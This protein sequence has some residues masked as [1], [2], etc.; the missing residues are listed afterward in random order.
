MEKGRVAIEREGALVEA[1]R[2]PW[3]I[4]PFDAESFDVAVIRICC[5]ADRHD[6][7]GR[8]WEM[9]RVLRP[10]DALVIEPPPAGGGFGG[11]RTPYRLPIRP[12]AGR[13]VRRCP[14]DVWFVGVRD[15]CR[16]ADGAQFTSKENSN[17]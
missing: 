16:K 9:L 5:R 3:G 13:P 2:A 17:I 11:S 7:R 15:A 4:W 14:N 10:V 1:T 8:V 6:A 12:Y